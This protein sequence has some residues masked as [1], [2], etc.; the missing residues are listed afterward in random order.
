VDVG[1]NVGDFALEV[2]NRFGCYVETYEPDIHAHLFI[3][4][5]I[6]CDRFVPFNRAV[7]GTTSV[8][9]FFVASPCAQGNSLISTHQHC[10]G[11][12]EST[13]YD[14]FC[15]SLSSIIERLGHIDLLKLDCEGAELEIIEKTPLD[16][17]SRIGQISIEFH[18]F[19]IPDQSAQQIEAAMA[20]IN[21]A[22]F[23]GPKKYGE[24][25]NTDCYYVRT[26]AH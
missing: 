24:C 6:L 18:D 1:G 19:C 17:L 7:T 8:R 3:A 15:V 9:R 25:N 14:V 12:A 26:A 22:G 10:Q 20:K 5:K 16:L 11:T 2:L 23:K 4:R 21:Q 13:S